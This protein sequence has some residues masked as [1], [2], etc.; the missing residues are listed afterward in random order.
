MTRFYDTNYLLE[1][2]KEIF[3]EEFYISALT[4]KELE[5]IKTSSHKD[6]AVKYQAR[7][8]IRLLSENEDKYNVVALSDEEMDLNFYSYLGDNADSRIILSAY[9]LAVNNNKQVEFYTYD[10]CCYHLAKVLECDNFKVVYPEDKE[11]ADEY[12]G[13][14]EVEMDDT[15][16]AEFYSNLTVNN[17]NLLLNQYLLIKDSTK[18]VVD[19]YRWTEEGFKKVSF[20]TFQSTEFGKVKPK[21]VYQAAAWDCL[22]NNQI[23]LLRGPAGSGKSYA[24]MTYLFSLLEKHKI[25]KVIVFCNPVATRDAAKLGLI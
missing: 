7:Q 15:E 9:Y 3:S 23:S 17:Y 18:E 8:I 13:F 6:N 4:L 25:D 22:K 2:S 1:K 24:A 21:D 11:S 12:T 14:L 5:N 20:N 19:S 10:R 16:L